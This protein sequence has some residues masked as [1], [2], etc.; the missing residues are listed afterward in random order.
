[1]VGTSFESLFCCN[2]VRSVHFWGSDLLCGISDWNK[3]RSYLV[4][5]LLYSYTF[6][7]GSWLKY[8]NIH[9]SDGLV[10]SCVSSYFEVCVCSHGW[11]AWPKRSSMYKQ[12]CGHVWKSSLHCYSGKYVISHLAGLSSWVALFIKWFEAMHCWL[13]L[14]FTSCSCQRYDSVSRQAKINLDLI[15]DGNG[16]LAKWRHVRGLGYKKNF[17]SV[18]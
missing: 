18:P 11:L 13:T 16:W 14:C 3:V 9:I 5:S 1:M 8:P 10:S 17:N 4:R 15:K 7:R 12:V 2:P 6:V